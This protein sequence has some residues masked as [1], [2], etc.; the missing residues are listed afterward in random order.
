MSAARNLLDQ[1]LDDRYRVHGELGR[2]DSGI[3][4]AAE[5]VRDGGRITLQVLQPELGQ[6]AELRASFLE[7]SLALTHAEHEHLIGVVGVGVTHDALC[8]VA[9]HPVEG[10]SLTQLLRHEALTTAQACSIASQILAGLHAAHAAG[11]VH[12]R[13][14]P[15]DIWVGRDEDGQPRIKLLGF[16]LAKYRP[17]TTS[18]ADLQNLAPECWQGGVSDPTTDLFSVAA[19]LFELLA[20]CPPFEGDTPEAVRA[21]AQRGEALGLANLR[22][23]LPPALVSLV[24]QGLSPDPKGRPTSAAEFARRLGAFG[25]PASVPEVGDHQWRSPIPEP[26]ASR[27]SRLP[28][29]RAMAAVAPRVSR[30]DPA[31]R[32]A[33]RGD[34]S[35]FLW[36]SES[37]LMDPRIPPPALTPNL[38]DDPP[39]ERHSSPSLSLSSEL[40]VSQR[41]LWWALVCG[42]IAGALLAWLAGAL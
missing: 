32:Y 40:H 4:Y 42:A 13:L 29:Q 8:Y 10:S 34:T 39:A 38:D 41:G 11:V 21:A 19:I 18:A 30:S 17:S 36:L 15:S 27:P 22:R 25:D 2:N 3:L 33:A 1:T 37:L 31:I 6:H 20:G 35:E 24:E 12:G 5:D 28:T 26:P 9:L 7:A 16:G 14:R 23:D